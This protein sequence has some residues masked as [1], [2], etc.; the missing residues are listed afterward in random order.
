MINQETFSFLKDLSA[1][2]NKPWMTEN[3][4]RYNEVKENLVDY[5]QTLIDEFSEIDPT[6]ARLDARKCMTRINRDMRF[7]K[8][9]PPYKDDFY[10]VLNKKQL[11]GVTAGYYLYIRPNNCFLGGGVWNP[12]KPELDR[13]R[14][15]VAD[16]YDDFKSI[17]DNASFKKKFPTG[18]QGDGTLVNVP[19]QFDE[20]HPAG[21]YLK[22]KGFCT[23]EKI[24]QKELM[25]K[26]SVKIVTSF[27]EASKPLVDFLNRGI[28]F[29][30]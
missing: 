4:E 14:K 30:Y 15:E 22:L 19:K 16:Y 29:E 26:D 23:K 8:N 13:Y 7:A 20:N 21:E 17:V 28:E 12:Q 2:N 24:T 10:L 9:A 25:S 18:I 6:I 1:N 5:V 11:H 3:K 27:F